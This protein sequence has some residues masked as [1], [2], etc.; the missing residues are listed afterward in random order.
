MTLELIDKQDNVE[1]IR[2]QIAA[3]LATEAASQQRLATAAGK[4][5]PEEWA[6]RVFQERSNVW[7]E[8]PI[9]EQNCV[10]LVNVWWDNST[11]DA[12]KSNIMERQKSDALINIDCYGY[13][14]SRDDPSGGHVPGDK[15]AAHAAQRAIRLVRNILFAA[16]YTYLGLQ[17]LVWQR[18]VESIN[19]FQPQQ[20]ETNASHVV[21]ARLALRVGFNEFS[22][23]VQPDTLELLSVTVFRTED[24]EVLVEA[25]YDYTGE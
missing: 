25:D 16:E 3:I 19:I 24:N 23:Q 4:L 2:D 17:G 5:N 11:F 9:D 7:Q 13:G 18:W 6:L 14:V 22:P 8:F 15:D 1:V 12:S 21:G 20:E 10:P